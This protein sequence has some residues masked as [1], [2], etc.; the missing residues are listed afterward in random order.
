ME[1]KNLNYTEFEI[2][3]TDNK[4]VLIIT[5][6]HN[7]HKQWHEADND[8]RLE[9]MISALR[10]ENE[11]KP[12]D[13]VLA[14]G[15]YSLDFWAWE[16]GGSYLW[17]EP[18]SRTKEFMEKYY[19]RIPKKMYMIP[20]NHEQYSNEDWKKITGFEREYAIVYGE[21]VFVML[22]TFAGD[23]GPKEDS[24][25]KYTGIN[26]PLVKAVL[27]NHPD[28]KIIL[29]LHDLMEDKESEEARKLICEEK[30]I[31][32]AFAGHRHRSNIRM[33]DEE[34][35][36]LAVVYSGDFSYNGGHLKERNWGFRI[37]ELDSG[38]STEYIRV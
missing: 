6:I 28:K 16:I 20:G 7:C 13:I 3:S 19:P 22:D 27:N 18:V 4:R 29:C 10:K 23:L 37:L 1:N 21:Y 35:R 36:N 26:V 14:L 15:D 24:D 25:G 9:Y 2:D 12:Y 32:C 30:R 31:I 5:D 11:Q 17:D 33:L 38:F 34:W 8:T